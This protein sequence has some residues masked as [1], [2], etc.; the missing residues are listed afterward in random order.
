MRKLLTKAEAAKRAGDYH[1]EHIMRLARLGQFPQ[2]IKLNPKPTGRVRFDADEV[3][4]WVEARA[5]ERSSAVLV[6]A[7]A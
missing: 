6:P 1:P 4:Q 3:E 7:A 2:P 5:A